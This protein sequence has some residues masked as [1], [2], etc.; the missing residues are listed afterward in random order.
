[1]NK[2]K[3]IVAK[4]QEAEFHCPKCWVYASQKWSLLKAKGWKYV[5]EN[6]G[7]YSA[8]DARVVFITELPKEYSTS[9]CEHC[10]KIAL[11]LGKNMIYPKKNLVDNPN[12]DLDK[13]I[14]EIYSE[15][16]NVLQ[17]SA[18]ASA[19]LLRLALQLLCKDLWW[20]WKNIND[21]IWYLV[22]EKNLPV[23]IQKSLDIVRITWNNAVHP[24]EIN[25]IEDRDKVLVL[26][27]LINFIAEKMISEPKELESMFIWLPE[28]AKDAIERRDA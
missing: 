16:A 23:Q 22:R 11:W 7:T 18:R 25:L 9:R 1:M 21:D 14:Q 17:D 20:K 27:K 2:E 5:G 3:Y 24:W 10:F 26:F 13:R 12:S 4:F 8:F 6:M 15:G 19:A 28:A